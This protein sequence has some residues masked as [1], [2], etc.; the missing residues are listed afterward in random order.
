[1]NLNHVSQRADV[2][3]GGAPTAPQPNSIPSGFTA[4]DPLLPEGG[5]P[6]GALTEILTIHEGVGALRLVTPALARL[7]D[8]DRWLAWIAPPYIPYAPALE[9]AGVDLSRV[10]LVHAQQQHDVLWAAEQALRSGT[11]GAVMAWLPEKIDPK[12]LRRLQLAAEAGGSLGLIFRPH[13][14]ADQASPAALRLLIEPAS[15]HTAVH[16]LKRRGGWPT[17]PL[18]LHLDHAAPASGGLSPEQLRQ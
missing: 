4:L 2:W 3:R 1:M 9:A 14:A 18:A 8:G 11:S 5:W 15:E 13:G 10:M 6:L 7:S 12:R 17:G 16:I